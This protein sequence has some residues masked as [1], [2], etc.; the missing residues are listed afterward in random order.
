MAST[1]RLLELLSLLQTGG[2]HSGPS[3][4]ERLEVTERTVR[5]DIDRLRQ[6]G[7]AI[8]SRRGASGSYALG[9]GGA[10][11]PPLILDRDETLALAVCVRAAAGE[12][13]SGIA[14]A[15]ERAL[16][17][18]HQSLPPRSRAEAD[19]LA[20][21]TVRVPSAGDE[22]DHDVLVTVTAACREGERLHL[23]YRD[24]SGRV[25]E[26]RIEPYRVVNVERRWYLV[27]HDLERQG[28]RTFRL[29]RFIAVR[30]TGHQIRL[31][32]P[33]DAASFVRS[34]ITTAPYRYQAVVIVDASIDALSPHV[35]PRFAALEPVDPTTTRLTAGADDLDYLVVRLGLLPFDLT[36]ESP[37]DLGRLMAEVGTRLVAA[38]HR[39]NPDPG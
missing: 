31:V 18:L 11:V 38:G 34:A 24:G 22:V 37:D 36:V 16:G 2:T 7:Y 15:A 30:R 17:K 8:E 25:T 27:A 28:W 20:M 21:A 39:S 19:A 9:A 1:A 32:D 13:V 5:R 23:D 33:P 4:A 6:L 35:A 3:I 26:R 14:A 29:D 12:S 10:S